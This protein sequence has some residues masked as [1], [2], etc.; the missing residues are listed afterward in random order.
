M[1]MRVAEEAG[2]FAIEIISSVR[3]Y[4]SEKSLSIKAE[5]AS[6][7][8]ECD[9]ETQKKLKPLLNE[10]KGNNEIKRIAFAAPGKGNIA[11]N[12]KIKIVISA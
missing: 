12:E 10:I 8:I 11:V 5:L 7:Q 6:V 1:M 4:K 3:K 9:D 2:N